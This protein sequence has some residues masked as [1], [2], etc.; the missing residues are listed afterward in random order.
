MHADV[1][2]TTPHSIEVH[3]VVS[4]LNPVSGSV[5]VTN[6]AQAW[7]VAKALDAHSPSRHHAFVN[8]RTSAEPQISQVSVAVPQLQH[9]N[10]ETERAGQQRWANQVLAY[11]REQVLLF[12]HR[13]LLTITTLQHII[14]N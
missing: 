11:H 9:P 1:V 2:F 4:A 14:S 7:Y 13:K 5:R 8:P 10:A 12:Q 6:I 3:V